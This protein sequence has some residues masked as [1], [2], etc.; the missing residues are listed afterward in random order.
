[1]IRGDGVRV[2]LDR[3]HV[4]EAQLVAEGRQQVPHQGAEP[5]GG[6][7]EQNGAGGWHPRV[8]FGW[9][10][11]ACTIFTSMDTLGSRAG[12]RQ[13]LCEMRKSADVMPVGAL[14]P[15]QRGT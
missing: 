12:L 1:E 8:S 3:A 10:A 4:E 11:H 2:A 5:A 6:A 9:R 13:V 15:P 14:D 7:G